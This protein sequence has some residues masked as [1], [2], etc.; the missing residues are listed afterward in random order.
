MGLPN[1]VETLENSA[2]WTDAELLECCSVVPEAPDVATF[3]FVSPSGALFRYLPGQFL[4]LELP[5]PG[6]TVWRTYTISS[7]PSRPLT[8]SITAK[9]Q[10]SDVE[11]GFVAGATDYVVKP[12]SPRELVSRV[13]AA[14]PPGSLAP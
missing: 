8:I 7:S 6:G 1:A 9:A 14:L 4:T 5:V 11:R 13:T 2:T 12:F 10:E 3:S